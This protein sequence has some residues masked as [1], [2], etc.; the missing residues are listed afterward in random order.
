MTISKSCS[1]NYYVS[2]LFEIKPHKYKL[3]N[4]KESIGLDFSPSEMY[5]SSENQ[6]GKDFGY[7]AQKQA[8]SKQLRKLFKTIS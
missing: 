4:R 8:H 3:E 6:T 5:V 1:G 7:I 2:I